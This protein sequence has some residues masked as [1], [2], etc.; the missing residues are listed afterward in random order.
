M[1]GWREGMRRKVYTLKGKAERKGIIKG[2][3]LMKKEGPYQKDKVRG[4][5]SFQAFPRLRRL[6]S[7]K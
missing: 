7:M 5:L 1:S 6:F 2:R 4:P 3:W